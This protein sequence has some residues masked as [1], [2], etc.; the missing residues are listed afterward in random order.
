MKR[1]VSQF[2]RDMEERNRC[3]G[4]I[5]MAKGRLKRFATWMEEHDVTCVSDVDYKNLTEFLTATLK[6]KAASYQAF[7]WNI[8]RSFLRFNEHELAQKY[9]YT[10]N[11]RGRQ[12]KWMTPEQMDFLM[13][14]KLTPREA[15]ILCAGLYAGLRRIELLRLTVADFQIALQTGELSVFAKGKVRPIPLH[16]DLRYA[17]EC[18]LE[19][20]DY[21]PGEKALQIHED[22]LSRILKHLGERIGVP[23]ASHVNRRSCFRFLNKK[24]VPLGTI[25]AIAGHSNSETTLRYIGQPMDDMKDAIMEIPTRLVRHVGVQITT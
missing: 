6:G 8:L 18:Y 12:V 11:G 17:M 4:Y 9:H 16:P 5:E 14:Q 3:P 7:C 2:I 25:S 10:P 24:G 22:T 21:G 13:S 20:V 1:S 15:L 19:T 23:C